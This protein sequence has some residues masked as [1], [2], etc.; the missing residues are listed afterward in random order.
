MKGFLT[1]QSAQASMINSSSVSLLKILRLST[2]VTS[3]ISTTP[4][5]RRL[6]DALSHPHRAVV[7]L[8]LLRLTRVVCDN[9][10]DRAT[11]VSRFDLA[12]IVDR[13]AKQ[14]EAILVRELAKEIYPS[15]LFGN[16]PPV[17]HPLT[18]S[19]LGV[20]EEGAPKR[21][22]GTMKRSSSD[23][24]PNGTGTATG[25]SSV[26]V[27]P[28]RAKSVNELAKDNLGHLLPKEGK[29]KLSKVDVSMTPVK[30]DDKPKH[31]RKISRSQLR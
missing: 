21:I 6:S 3:S 4:F 9:H 27:V 11:L 17:Y 22:L 12:K 25:G 19:T 13:L 26:I 29:V 24:A 8:N 15:L 30:E 16:D 28:D 23:N 7:K 5:F 2:S 18:A 10:P 14:D 31:K 1:R 20:A